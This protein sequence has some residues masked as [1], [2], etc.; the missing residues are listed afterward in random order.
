MKKKCKKSL[1]YKLRINTHTL[2]AT[3]CIMRRLSKCFE[4]G[5][6]YHGYRDNYVSVLFAFKPTKVPKTSPFGILC[7][8]VCYIFN[9]DALM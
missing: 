1:P 5:F 6:C 3:V 9:S 4:A 8:F 7:V 2:K